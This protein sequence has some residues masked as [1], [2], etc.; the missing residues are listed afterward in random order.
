MPKPYRIGKNLTIE[1][2]RRRFNDGLRY[3]DILLGSNRATILRVA[4]SDPPTKVLKLSLR[5][6]LKQ[7]GDYLQKVHTSICFSDLFKKFGQQNLVP[8]C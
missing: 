4:L 3:I 2:Y 7:K 8:H 6:F 5:V 1:L